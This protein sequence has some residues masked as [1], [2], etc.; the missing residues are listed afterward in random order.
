MSHIL[1]HNWKSCVNTVSTYKSYVRNAVEPQAYYILAGRILWI[2]CFKKSV[3]SA[4]GIVIELK[5]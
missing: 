1:K 4:L 2:F 5:M 3:D